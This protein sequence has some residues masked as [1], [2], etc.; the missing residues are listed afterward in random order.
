MWRGETVVERARVSVTQEPQTGVCQN[1]GPDPISNTHA[2]EG[3]DNG[4]G[5]TSEEPKEEADRGDEGSD[6]SE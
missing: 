2:E 3:A 4:N 5:K 6:S 1:Q